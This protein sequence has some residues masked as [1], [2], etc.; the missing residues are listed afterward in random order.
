LSHVFNFDV[1]IHAE[2][3]VHRIGRTGR[4]GL[5]GHAF[6]LATPDDRLFVD[7]IEKLIGAPIPRMQVEGMEEVAFAEDDGKRRR[8]RGRGTKVA[9]RAAKVAKPVTEPAEGEAAPKAAKP[10]R[11]R[12]KKSDAVPAAPDVLQP[13][14]MTAPATIEAP[15]AV[16]PIPTQVIEQAPP[17]QA[18]TGRSEPRRGGRNEPRR[19]EPR[20]PD[21][22]A[23][24]MRAGDSRGG[25]RGRPRDHRRRDEDLG[26]AVL[27]FG[28]D[29]P[30]FMLLRSRAARSPAPEPVESE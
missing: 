8:G 23:P 26:P 1:P 30:A 24:D 17:A 11:S 2:D 21:V 7:A 4:A 6:T 18:R 22:R 3:Y 20:Q 27:G 13:E 15:A 14:T 25:D 16:P 10:R 5:T 9:P 12:A 29:V 19:E 28:D